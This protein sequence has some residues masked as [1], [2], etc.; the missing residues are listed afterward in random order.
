MPRTKRLLPPSDVALHLTARGNNHLYL[1]R[2]DSDKTYYLSAAEKLKAENG[3]DIFHYCLMDNHVHLIVWLQQQS[4]LSRFMKQLQ[5]MYFSYY[6]AAYDYA[7]HL[8]QGRF[9]SN[10][11]DNDTYLL[12]CGKYI[13]L[14][15]ERA[16]MVA[17]PDEYC[18]SS[19][20]YY[21][22][23]DQ[24]SLLTPSPAYLG[25]ANTAEGR[26]RR[27]ISCTVDSNLINTR[28]LQGQLFLGGEAFVRRLEE[29]YQIRNRALVRGRPR[30]TEK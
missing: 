6:K 10:L 17:S 7:G 13:E 22:Y 11:V 9:K 21:A 2:S 20:R 4:N 1:F 5:L 27:Y 29:Y 30:K 24:D 18:F 26:R 3:I 19:Y 16:G 8:W 23:G 14:N 25:L 15:P 28:K 12:Q